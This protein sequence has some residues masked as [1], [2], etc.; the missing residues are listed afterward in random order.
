M[1]EAVTRIGVESPLRRNRM[2]G[3]EPKH[4]VQLDQRRAFSEGGTR[5][6]RGVGHVCD[7]D[8]RAADGWMGG[9]GLLFRK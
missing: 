9:E 8:R 2:I 3:S 7:S 6:I 1:L 4:A 5:E